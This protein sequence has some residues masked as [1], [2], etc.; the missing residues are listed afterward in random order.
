MFVPLTDGAN[1]MY[2][3]TQVVSNSRAKSPIYEN[4]SDLEM[5][6]PGRA[7]RGIRV[8]NELTM[9]WNERN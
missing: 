1:G 6:T 3:K 2:N 5:Q 8:K 7:A 9:E 4:G